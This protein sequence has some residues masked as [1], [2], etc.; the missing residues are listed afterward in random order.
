MSLPT[1]KYSKI[2]DVKSP[3]KADDGAA[4]IDFFVPNDFKEEIILDGK[5]YSI[6]LGLKVNI[7]TGYCLQLLD[8]S[9]LAKKRGITIKAGLIDESYQG[10]ICAI[11]EC[12]K[13]QYPYTLKAGTKLLQGKIEKV[14]NFPM[15]EVKESKLFPT[16]SKRGE[17]G[18]GS[19]GNE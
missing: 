11:I 15:K 7:P 10:E 6:P 12:T 17:G 14:Y 13:R 18:F 2:R 19:S 9:G 5:I 16:K 3:V 8:R 4:G 1:L